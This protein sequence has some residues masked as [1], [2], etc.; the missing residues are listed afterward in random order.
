MDECWRELPR[1][2]F[3]MHMLPWL[4]IDM[5]RAFG[6]FGRLS[7]RQLGLNLHVKAIETGYMRD[8]D[9]FIK[10]V[11]GE[12]TYRHCRFYKAGRDTLLERMIVASDG[13]CSILWDPSDPT[14]PA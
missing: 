11:V 1:E 4:S 9:S 13:V 10:W 2:V 3:E 12:R 6:V 7:Q 14:I 5:R 8:E